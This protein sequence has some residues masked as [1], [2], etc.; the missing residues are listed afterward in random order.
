M[1]DA[2]MLDP[3]LAARCGFTEP[4]RGRQGTAAR[5][6]RVDTSGERRAMTR[7][8]YLLDESKLA[9]LD[10]LGR[11]E[12]AHQTKA[13]PFQITL[14]KRPGPAD[15]F[16]AIVLQGAPKPVPTAPPTPVPPTPSLDGGPPPAP[17]R[18]PSNRKR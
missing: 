7:R 15:G 6:D 3:M 11:L 18:T 12:L 10:R 1:L 2:V 4:R 5:L 9:Q 13:G 17:D 8:Q 14:T 16:D